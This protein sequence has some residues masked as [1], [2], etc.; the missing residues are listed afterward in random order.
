MIEEGFDAGI[1]AGAIPDANIVARKLAD[2]PRVVCAAPAYL[3][4]H[5]EPRA[6]RDLTAH[7]CIRYRSLQTGR[8][9]RWEFGA[10]AREGLDVEGSLTLNDMAA[11]CD[12][13][14]AGHGLAQLPAFIAIAH[15][16]SGRLMPVLTGYPAPAYALFLH[17]PAR[18]LLP[19]RVRAFVD[20][21]L[22]R[23][24]GHP[25]LAFDPTA[26]WQ[27]REPPPARSRRSYAA[28]A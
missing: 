16:R 4:R 18:R 24:A 9:L 20:F 19:A 5:G 22:E 3:E 21:L 1:R 15:L 27:R 7:D 26:P 25:D 11:V 28:A 17:Y 2:V 6:P 8:T 23:L 10:D 14:L 13:A 12:A